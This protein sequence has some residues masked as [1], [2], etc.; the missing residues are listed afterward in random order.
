MS[1]RYEKEEFKGIGAPFSHGTSA[2]CMAVQAVLSSR[3]IE[4]TGH[5]NYFVTNLLC[6]PA[7]EQ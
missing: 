1:P 2:H 7:I 5:V 4:M 6:Y 3:S